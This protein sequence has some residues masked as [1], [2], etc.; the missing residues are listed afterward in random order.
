MRWALV[1]LSCAA[2]NQAFGLE[3][4]HAID[5]LADTDGDGVP[6]IA[7]N[8][9]GLANADQADLDRDGVGDV[10]DDCP[11]VPN[12]PT[13]PG[14]PQ[15]DHDAD[16]IGDACDPRPVQA[17]ECLLL[18][19]A[20]RDASVFAAHWR[21]EPTSASAALSVAPGAIAITPGATPA[22]FV[23]VDSYGAISSIEVRGSLGA[24]RLAPGNEVGLATAESASFAGGYWCRLDDTGAT[25][26]GPEVVVFDG[27]NSQSF[28]PMSGDSGVDPTLLL[29]IVVNPAHVRCRIDWGIEVG[30]AESLDVATVSGGAAAGVY[31]QNV[32]YTVTGIALYGAAA[33][34]PAT[35]VR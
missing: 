1:A 20:F 21:A 23:S 7:D 29:R 14:V 35:I 26:A 34:C 6:D 25:I 10:C 27:G 17:G 9:P 13:T 8:C 12:P 2:C 3:R 19:D 5:A 32:P 15:D 18:F 22:G 31:A 28:A 30:A 33:P 24:S 16:G 11:L 4:T